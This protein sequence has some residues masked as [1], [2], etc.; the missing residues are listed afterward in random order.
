[1]TGEDSIVTFANLLLLISEVID[2]NYLERN[3]YLSRAKDVEYC[4]LGKV[5][6]KASNLA[7]QYIASRNG[8]H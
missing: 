6:T 8:N 4:V 7:S 1:M 3:I 5:I 2:H